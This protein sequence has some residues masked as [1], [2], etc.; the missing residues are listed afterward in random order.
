MSVPVE[1]YPDAGHAFFADHRPNYRA[2]AAFALWP[3]VTGFLATHLQ[4][5]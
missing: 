4:A 1:I 2:E 5:T 3:R